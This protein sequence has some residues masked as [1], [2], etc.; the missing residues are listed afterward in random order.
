MMNNFLILLL[1][2][3]F[4]SVLVLSDSKAG[5]PPDSLGFLK[6][7]PT[8]PLGWNSWDCYGPTVTEKVVKANTYY[9]VKHLKEFGWK[10]IV[11]DI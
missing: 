8:P 10:Y 7:A 4:L 1:I 11:I 9:M 2:V 6:W 5:C 3:L